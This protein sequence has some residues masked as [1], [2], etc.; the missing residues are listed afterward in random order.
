MR[1]P[2]IAIPL[3]V[4]TAC[5]PASHDPGIAGSGTKASATRAVAAFNGLLVKTSA[6]VTVKVGGPPSVT[7]ETDDN[8]LANIT[9][10]SSSGVLTIASDKPF[11]THLGVKVAVSAPALDSV[12]A[13][14]SGTIDATGVKTESFRLELLGSGAATVQGTAERALV[15]LSGSGSERLFGLVAKRVEVN[16]T[17]SGD[18]E[19]HASEALKATITGSGNVVYEGGPPKVDREVIGSGTIKPR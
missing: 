1:S 16:L 6:D 12:V 15:T 9:T 14:G 13:A 19:V 11:T 3:F 8:L 7:I 5:N 2:F 17:G 4:L 10:D 18:V